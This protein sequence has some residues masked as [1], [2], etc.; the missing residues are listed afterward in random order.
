L[1]ILRLYKNV[2]YNLSKIRFKYLKN[3]E[4]IEEYFIDTFVSELKSLDK[5]KIKHKYFL[6]S[7]NIYSFSDNEI[8][9]KFQ[10]FGFNNINV[11]EP[12]LQYEEEC[13]CQNN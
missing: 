11:L 10:S 1:T 5:L 13:E 6:L 9:E 3:F 12:P 2:E 7:K 8:I 4:F